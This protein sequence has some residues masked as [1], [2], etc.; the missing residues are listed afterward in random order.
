MALKIISVL[1]LL[2]LGSNDTTLTITPKEEEPPPKA[3]KRAVASEIEVV[4]LESTPVC[5]TSASFAS[6]MDFRAITR[7]T[8]YDLQQVAITNEKGYREIDGRIMIAIHSQY[9]SVGDK[10]KI[11]FSDD[12]QVNVIIG[13]IKAN[14]DCSH[15]V[16]E[17]EQSIIEVIV[18]TT[19]ITDRRLGKIKEYSKT[20]NKI[21]KE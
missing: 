6:Y 11:T 7:H 15:Y 21:E 8:Q 13:D 19:I 3:I 2:V 20:I 4:E 14:T 1:L 17:N 9:G 10:L 5:D 16:N 18:D 12:S